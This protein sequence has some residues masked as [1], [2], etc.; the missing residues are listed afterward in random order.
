MRGNAKHLLLALL[1]AALAGSAAA[2]DQDRDK[3][4]KRVREAGTVLQ[5]I[6]SAPDKGIPE[7]IIG[8]AKCVAV[9][10]SLLSGGFIFGGEFGSGV[11]SCRLANGKDWST[12]AFF[13]VKGGSFGLQIG[14]RAVDLVML[15][16]DERGMKNLLSSQFELGANASVAAGP[17]GRQ[18]EGNTDWK[19]RAQVLTYSR[20]RGIFAGMA[21]KGALVRQDKDD[22]RR[23]YGH[24]VTYRTLLT[25]HLEPPAEAEPFLSA[26]KKYASG[27]NTPEEKTAST[28][29]SSAEK[30]SGGA[31]Q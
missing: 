8:S 19:M 4:V 30:K 9:V 11:A 21:L 25:G 16:M 28:S 2:Q 20:A 14:G 17:V 26:L 31:E 22:T 12:P 24:M 6:M 3:Q 27:N 5:E 15:L 10:P 18:A 7:D 13:D 1:I 29:A 23:F